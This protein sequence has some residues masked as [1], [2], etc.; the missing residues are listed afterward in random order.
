MHPDVVKTIL[1]GASA[2]EVCS[3]LY[4]QGPDFIQRSTGFLAQWLEDK[5]IASVEQ[6]RGRLNQKNVRDTSTFERAQFMRY[7]SSREA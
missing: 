2:V 5:G 3:A 6:A 7:F 1:A 4:E